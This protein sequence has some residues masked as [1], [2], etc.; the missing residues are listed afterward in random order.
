MLKR[1]KEA[2]LAFLSFLRTQLS[3]DITDIKEQSKETSVLL[4][5]FV[6]FKN[7]SDKKVSREVHTPS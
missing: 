4:T 7:L 3:K 6:L 2:F 5:N 1:H